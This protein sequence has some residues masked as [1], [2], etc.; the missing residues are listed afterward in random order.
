MYRVV[1]CTGLAATLAA[2]SLGSSS[3]PSGFVE[4]SPPSTTASVSKS[5]SAALGGEPGRARNVQLASLDK[6]P[7]GTF[8]RP[9]P[10]ILSD[11]DYSHTRLN[12]EMAR[13][14]INAYRKEN[15]LKPLKLNPELTE[16]AKES[17]AR[18]GK[19]GSHFTLRVRW[20]KPVGSR[21]ADRLQSA[22]CG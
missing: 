1:I 15:G 13:D 7:A 18:S 9:E 16:A 20:L 3:L 6:A 14:I 12:A 8:E 10:G 22:A 5:R 17:L 19:M 4:S 2:C 21:Q 11:R